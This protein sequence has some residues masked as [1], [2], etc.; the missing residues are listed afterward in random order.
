MRASGG[1][2]G[3]ARAAGAV[4][5]LVAAAG[6]AASCTGPAAGHGPPAHVRVTARTR[7]PAPATSVLA[8]APDTVADGVASRLFASAPVVVVASPGGPAGLS[9]AARSA[10][11]A[12]APLLMA[13]RP[14]A[15]GR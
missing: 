13:G 7:V 1:R 2:A 8:G 14:A 12:H 4:L 15:P 11:R 9:A 3:I 5:M 6:G 10:L